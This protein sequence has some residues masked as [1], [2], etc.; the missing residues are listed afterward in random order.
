MTS[1]VTRGERT[2]GAA[3]LVPSSAYQFALPLEQVGFALMG[4][5]VVYMDET[6]GMATSLLAVPRRGRLLAACSLAHAPPACQEAGLSSLV[7]MRSSLSLRRYPSGSS[8]P[9]AASAPVR[10]SAGMRGAIAGGD[11][12]GVPLDPL[13]E[14]KS[15]DEHPAGPV[16]EPSEREGIARPPGEPAHLV[17]PDSQ[18]DRDVG[19]AVVVLKGDVAPAPVRSGHGRLTSSA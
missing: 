19:D 9:I 10:P 16:R 4:A 17:L 11:E 15:G 1:L 6:G 14:L 5:L 12:D 3:G 2:D 8:P 18:Q 7:Q 13:H